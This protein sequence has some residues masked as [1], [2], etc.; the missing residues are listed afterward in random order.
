MCIAVHKYVCD[1]KVFNI[2]P[3][4]VA[5]GAPGHIC[6]YYQLISCWPGTSCD[7]VGQSQDY[8]VLEF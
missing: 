5:V 2:S 7:N 3:M 6:V 4:H 8:C 1:D